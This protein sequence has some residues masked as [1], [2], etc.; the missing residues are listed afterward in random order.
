MPQPQLSLNQFQ[1]QTIVGVQ[2]FE[3]PGVIQTLQAVISPNQATALSA[4]Q[5]VQFDT[6]ITAAGL[7]NIIAAAP[8]VYADA[9]LLYDIQK[10]QSQFVSGAVVQIALGGILQMLA[11]ATIEPGNVVQDNT[12]DPGGVAPWATTGYYPRGVAIDYGVAGQIVRVNL[13][14]FAI[15]AA[16]AAAHA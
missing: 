14:P 7:P 4:G 13:A 5:A 6:A 11:E 2:A 1:L 16:Q 3:G 10:S 8:N 12:T 9:Y 15:K